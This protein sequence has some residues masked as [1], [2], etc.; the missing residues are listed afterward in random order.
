MNPQD[1]YHAVSWKEPIIYE[2]GRKGRRGHKVPETDQ[3]IRAAVGDVVSRIPSNMRRTDPPKLPELSEPEVVRHFIRLSQETYGV[4]SGIHIHGTCTMKYSPRINE[5]LIRSQKLA[6]IHPMQDP[7]TVQG[8]LKIMYELQGTLCEL[9]GMDAFSLQPRGGAHAVF[10]NA[11]MIR[12]YH[13]QRGELEQRNEIITTVLSHP[14]NGGSPAAAGFRVVTLYPNERTGYPDIDAFKQAVSKHTAGLMITDPYD[15]GV[16]DSNIDEYIRMIHEAGGLVAVDQAN[17]NSIL[18]RI[19]I[20]DIGADLCHFNLH[21]SFSTPHGSTGPGSAPIGVKAELSQF[22]PVPT[23]AYDGQKYYLDYDRPHSIGKVGEFYGVIPNIVRAYSWL[24]LM[25]AD[26]LREVSE[27]AVINNNYLISRISEIRGITLPWA[28]AHPLRLQEARF[29]LGRMKEET[30]V[31]IDDVNRRIV[32]FGL[33]DMETSHEPWIIPEP[34]TPEPP[35]TTSKEDLDRFSDVLQ[36][37]SEEAYSNPDLVRTAP[38][39]AAI[40]KIDRSPS[41]NPQKW[42]MTWR[43]YLKKRAPARN[44]QALR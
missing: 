40:G 34:L 19:R 25:G 11:H 31:G 2:L 39:N 12:A 3:E 17:A 1:E 4:D 5:T 38:H 35:E 14:C 18:G 26:G 37:I 6:D 8:I 27:V 9:S 10:S 22:L 15:T 36:R 20:G 29:S 42:A 30:G 33:Q 28:E 44:E 13:M 23:V 21:K 16:F 7:E 43:A 41:R 24:L 32:D